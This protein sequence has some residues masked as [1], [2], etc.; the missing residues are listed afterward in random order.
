MVVTG[1]EI[2]GVV[3]SSLS[4]LNLARTVTESLISTFKHFGNAG[5]ELYDLSERFRS[6]QGR[7]DTWATETWQISNNTSVEHYQ[8][9]W[10]LEGWRSIASQ[11]R[12]I[13]KTCE[14]VTTLLAH[15]LTEE[16]R[17][18]VERKHGTQL[19]KIS[20]ANP[21]KRRDSQAEQAS[22]SQSSS[23]NS[24]LSIVRSYNRKR[25]VD[26]LRKLEKKAKKAAKFDQKAS[27]ILKN[28]T[29]L[30]DSMSR[31]DSMF[32][33]LEHDANER[34]Y[35]QFPHLSRNASQQDRLEATRQSLLLERAFG[36]R[37][38]SKAFYKWCTSTR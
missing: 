17:K 25:E 14:D 10:G 6:F 22:D 21:F 20:R 30:T 2:F 1:F 3:A 31:L 7:L 12:M 23:A 27:F 26:E 36:S 28:L 24:A 5:A 9:I 19:S 15:L 29:Q 11:I 37:E 13:D 32:A 8:A 4:T 33:A 35:V 34:F 18:A 38:A 16:Q